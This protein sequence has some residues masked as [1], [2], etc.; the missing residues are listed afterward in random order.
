MFYTVETGRLKSPIYKVKWTFK[1]RPNSRIHYSLC[2]LYE[3]A[4]VLST[5]QQSDLFQDCHVAL[6]IAMTVITVWQ[7]CFTN[8]LAEYKYLTACHI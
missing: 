3:Q 7:F 5:A 4:R 8:L 2:S 1:V 6:L